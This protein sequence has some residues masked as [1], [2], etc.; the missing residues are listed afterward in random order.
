MNP[1]TVEVLLKPAPELENLFHAIFGMVPEGTKVITSAA[2]AA[3]PQPAVAPQAE[4]PQPPTPPIAPAAPPAVPTT[5][6]VYTLDELSRAGAALLD[7]G[8][9]AEAL[10]LM[11]QFG[12]QAITDLKVE[13]YGAFA[14]ELRKLGAKI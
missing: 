9:G 11:G 7:T 14:T 8:K 13:Q 2:P 10:A 3:A 5:E 1:I 12:I 4:T 6:R